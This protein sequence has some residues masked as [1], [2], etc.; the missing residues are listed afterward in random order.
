MAQNLVVNFIGENKLSKTTAVVSS[1]LRKFGNT[2]KQVG[3]NLN[4][5]LGAAGLGLGIASL[6]RYLVTATQGF[7][8]AQIASRKLGSVL[9]SMG[10]GTATARVDAYAESL[11]NLVGIDAD[12]IKGTQT[13][14]GT[15]S[16][17]TSTIDKAGGVFDRAT[18][19]AFDLA[20]AGIGTAERNAIQLGKALQDP[21]RGLTSLRKSGVTFTEQEK[22]KIKTLVESNRTLEAQDLILSAIETQVGGTAAAGASSFA[23]L[24]LTFDSIADTIGESLLPAVQQF[25][26][27]LNSPSGKRNV[28]QIADIFVSVGKAVS[29]ATKFVL[30]NI[31]VIKA[32]VAALITVKLG[33]MAITGAVKIYE[34]AVNIATIKTKLLK[35]AL[36][37]TGIGALVVALGTLASAFIDVGDAAEES[38]NKVTA[39]DLQNGETFWE[40][41]ARKQSEA[42]GKSYGA[43]ADT[44]TKNIKTTTKKITK[45]ISQGAKE[46]LTAGKTFRDSIGLA[47]GTFGRDENSVFNVDV[48]INKLKRVVDA[49]KGFKDNLARLTKAGAGQDVIQELIGM[50]PAQGNIVAKGLLQ[51]GKL[52]QYLGLRGSLFKTGEEVGALAQ[53]TGEKNYSININKAN[54]SAEDIIRAIRSYEKKHGTKY[55]V[56]N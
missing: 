52:S 49:A 38:R 53:A 19:A 34:L 54:V 8:K 28:K 30:K 5:A 4:R 20:S 18:V 44:E 21:I 32:L 46:V 15:F 41:Q 16:G 55:F 17:L 25:N 42:W 1:D 10:V 37:T 3:N 22:A 39:D 45:A 35:V 29:D 33:W 24:Q 48:V 56:G 23:R 7:E 12:V 43:K 40:Y 11:Q 2:A 6:S 14:L 50:G 36:V 51:S 27:F 26:T 47:L 13:I 9:E 31:A